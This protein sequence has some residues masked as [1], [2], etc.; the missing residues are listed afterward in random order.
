M[1][2][3]EYQEKAHSFAVYPD[4]VYYPFLGLGS[5]VGELQGKIK[6]LIR[7]KGVTDLRSLSEDDK[8]DIKSE[9]SDVLWYLSEAAG[10]VGEGLEQIAHLNLVK[11]TSRKMRGVLKGNGDAR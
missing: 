10:L 3:N 9:L 11:L 1:T 6:K 8:Y 7:D 4:N 2:F 5:E